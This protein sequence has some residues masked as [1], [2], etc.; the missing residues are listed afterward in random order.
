MDTFEKERKNGNYKKTLLKDEKKA[1]RRE[2]IQQCAEKMMS[3]K[4][5]EIRELEFYLDNNL[6]D[7]E[8]E[9]LME[10]GFSRSD[11]LRSSSRNYMR[12]TFHELEDSWWLLR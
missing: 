7:R 3:N 1:E 9:E 4:K 2:L 10:L 5:R 11:A 6:L 12:G 8:V